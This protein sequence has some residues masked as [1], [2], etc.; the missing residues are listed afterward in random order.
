MN[1]H[2]RNFS[3]DMCQNE[4]N[5]QSSFPYFWCIAIALE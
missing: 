2:L 5:P 4:V 1:I 3:K